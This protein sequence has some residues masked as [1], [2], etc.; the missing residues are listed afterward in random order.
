MVWEDIMKGKKIL[1]IV[2]VIAVVGALK[3]HIQTSKYLQHTEEGSNIEFLYQQKFLTN[4]D[5]LDVR[6]MFDL[7]IVNH[8]KKI[9]IPID[10][11]TS[12]NKSDREWDFAKHY[13]AWGY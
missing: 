5:G 4:L 6:C 9:I 7:L 8:T 12:C 2:A 10:L 1:I 13:V 11:K 3:G